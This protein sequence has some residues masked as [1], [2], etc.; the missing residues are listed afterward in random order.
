[1]EAQIWREWDPVKMEAEAE[2]VCLQAKD[3]GQK[4]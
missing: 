4:Q 1:M 2:V 3:C